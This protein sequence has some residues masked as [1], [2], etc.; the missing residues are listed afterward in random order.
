[1]LQT[2]VTGLHVRPPALVLAALV[3][4]AP[5][6]AQEAQV[7]P[8]P[9]V[10]ASQIAEAM[11]PRPLEL[12]L[13]H[14]EALGL[15]AA[16]L[17]RLAAIRERLAAANEPLVNRMLELRREWQQQRRAERRERNEH[18]AARLARIRTAAQPLHTRIQRNNRTAMQAVNRLLTRDQRA[19]LRAIVEHRRQ[20]DVS[21]P[22]PDGSPDAGGRN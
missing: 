11:P 5:A 20:M 10:P 18:N 2:V 19:K 7:Q 9:D 15:T 8:K 3:L 4:A 13:E 6:V 12:L 16:Q 22:D 21:P 1:M 14:R 17:D